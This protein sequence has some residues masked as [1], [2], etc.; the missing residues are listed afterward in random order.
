M[1][2]RFVKRINTIAIIL[3][4]KNNGCFRSKGYKKDNKLFC[5]YNI[6]VNRLNWNL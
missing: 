5:V 3:L 1:N 2:A 4:D 6:Y